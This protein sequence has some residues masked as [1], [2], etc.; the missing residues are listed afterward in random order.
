VT[1]TSHD[2]TPGRPG[3]RRPLLLATIVAVLAIG[4]AL[5]SLRL[6]ASQRRI[7]SPQ[8]SAVVPAGTA[9]KSS[10]SPAT[11]RPNATPTPTR[12]SI[13]SGHPV[14]AAFYYP[15]F[16]QAWTQSG[17]FPFTN[18]HPSDGFYATN[19]VSVIKRQIADMRYGGLNA[20]I[21]SWWG[22]GSYED[23]RIPELLAAGGQGFSWALYDELEGVGDPTVSKISA[24][25]RYIDERYAGSPSYL[26]INGR[27]VIFVYSDGRDGC[28]MVDR[29]HQANTLGFYVVLRV[30]PGYAACPQQ[31]QGWHQYAPAQAFDQQGKF[32]FTVSPGFWKAGG[33]SRLSRDLT[34]FATDVAAMAASRAQFQLITTY[35][36]W[37][38]GTPVE[39]AD[40]WLSAS[41]HG[42]Y[43]DVLHREL[44]TPVR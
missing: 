4:I 10:S 13:P 34:R 15:W 5:V 16:P 9:K 6:S 22:Q 33:P 29:W 27:P 35:N 43:M 30:F 17:R 28:R 24:D 1:R 12:M 37:G 11:P 25:L 18:Y 31:P 40:E 44:A 19:S 14:R 21:A 20:A 3:S 7:S 2:P 41:G 36:E 32:S 26:H 8:S 42:A 39:S 38:E 23:L